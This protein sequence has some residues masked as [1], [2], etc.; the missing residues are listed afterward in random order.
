MYKR[1]PKPP[2]FLWE[3]GASAN[4]KTP[5]IPTEFS[6]GI[7]MVYTK[8]IPEGSHRNTESGYNSM[9]SARSC[10]SSTTYKDLRS[11]SS[12]FVLD[13]MAWCWICLVQR[14]FY[15]QSFWSCSFF[16]SFIPGIL[17]YSISFGPTTRLWRPRPSILSLQTPANT[18]SSSW[19]ALTRKGALL[20]RLQM[21]MSIDGVKSG[22]RLLSGSLPVL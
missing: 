4:F 22:V 16:T 13:L 19:L 1:G 2:P 20:P 9:H 21:Q 6:F 17:T 8:K 12:S 11:R 18:M 5:K 15:P 7:G 3:K 14:F 10:P